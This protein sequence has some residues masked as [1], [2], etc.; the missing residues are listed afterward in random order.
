MRAQSGNAT[1]DVLRRMRNPQENLMCSAENPCHH[2]E[3]KMKSRDVAIR[4]RKP[5]A[6]WELKVEGGR[7]LDDKSTVW[8]SYASTCT[9]RNRGISVEW[10]GASPNN[11]KYRGNCY[12]TPLFF[13]KLKSNVCALTHATCPDANLLA[14]TIFALTFTQQENGA[15]AQF[16]ALA[17][18]VITLRIQGASP[19]T[20]SMPSAPTWT[21]FLTHHSHLP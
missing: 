8:Y 4:N 17:S 21:P 11:A 13:F 2:H 18:R 12:N 1:R 14:A 15:C 20:T 16:L 19:E 5:M 10:R 3:T 6:G 7:R 9:V